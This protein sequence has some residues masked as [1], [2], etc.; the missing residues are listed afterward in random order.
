[1]LAITR[2]SRPRG[3][4]GAALFA[5]AWLAVSAP[6]SS[7]HGQA[8]YYRSIPIGE[9]AVGLGGAFTGLAN[10]PSATYYNPAGMT[11]GGRFELLGSFSSLLLSR[12]KIDDAFLS[13]NT[14]AD[15][16]KKTTATLP[17]FIGTV[18]RLG[19]A[20]HGRD[21]QF[22]I[23]YSTLEVSREIFGDTFSE[24]NAADSTDIRI[25]DRYRDRWYGVSFAAQVTR[26]SSVGF[27]IFLADQSLSYTE[28][29]GIASGGEFNPDNGLRI[30]GESLTTSGDV[31]A[32]AY[33]F[34]ARLGWLHEVNEQW[35]VGLMFQPPGIPL[36]Q[37][38]RFLRRVT[39]T[40][41]NEDGTFTLF[42][43]D[44][45]GGR[46]PIP[47]ELTAGF[48]WRFND[49]SLLTFDASVT[50]P[51]RAGRVVKVDTP[52]T[53][54]R[55]G[56]YF[57]GDTRRRPVPNFAVGAEHR[58]NKVVLAS[59]FFTNF[60]AA[61]S[62]P[63]QS[64]D[65][66]PF[67]VNLWGV[68][69]AFGLDYNGYRFTV[70]TTAMVGPGNALSATIDERGDVLSYERTRARRAIVLL[71]LA[72]AISV[73]T[74]AGKAVTERYE[75]R[76]EEEATVDTEEGAKEDDQKGAGSGDTGA[77]QIDTDEGL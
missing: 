5:A 66:S 75:D 52:D 30:G 19:R 54:Q 58:F 3:L 28:S 27:S 35:S 57:S 43:E 40:F 22:A 4:L 65:Y 39:T 68:S 29:I 49:T 34:V 9:R 33:H 63:A 24:I 76:K 32:R 48:S 67:Q 50:G 15:F 16:S 25:D 26:P 47:F 59:G 13:P 77:E 18:V 36:S 70:G 23:G 14:Q 20:K 1:M 46:L 60:S 2:A 12:T 69:T 17:R 61:P 51:V 38:G 6:A 10:D 44:G 8:L 64:D 71:Y 73:A 45:A 11:S 74:K 21:H 42:D 37:S 7:T 56:V 53:I 55:A 31:G 62:V 72:G 41:P